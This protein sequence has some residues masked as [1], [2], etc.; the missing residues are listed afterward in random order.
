VYLHILPYATYPTVEAN[1]THSKKSLRQI[2]HTQKNRAGKTPYGNFSSTEIPS[3]RR[4]I[5][6]RQFSS[7]QF[8]HGQFQLASESSSR[9]L[10]RAGG[11]R[12]SPAAASYASSTSY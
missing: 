4:E 1:F 12:S 3:Y 9:D 7:R 10:K 2:L 6:R 8:P 5:C 11:G